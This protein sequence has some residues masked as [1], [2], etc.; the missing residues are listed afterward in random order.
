LC[1]AKE[2]GISEDHS[3]LLLLSPDARP[4]IGVAQFLDLT[5]VPAADHVLELAILPNIARCQS[6]RGC[7]REIAALVGVQAALDVPLCPITPGGEATAPV[8][9]EP[10]LCGR[11]SV[12]KVRGLTVGPSPAWQQRRLLLAGVD[13]INNLVDATNYVLLEFGQP[14]HAYDADRLSS[15]TLGVRKS[16][17][18]ET[19]HTLTQGEDDA[20]LAL[21]IGTLL[22]TSADQPVA[23][24]GI[25]GGRECSIGETTTTV[26][27]ECANFDFL[28][29]RRS[30]V[31]LSLFTEAASRFSRG[32]DIET[33]WVGLERW[34]A[35]VRETC[36]DA[37]VVGAA[38]RRIRPTEICQITLTLQEVAD[39]LGADLDAETVLN[40]LRRVGLSVALDSDR[41]TVTVP[42]Y[43]NDLTLPCDVVEEVGRL[44]GYDRLPTTLPEEALPS[45]PRNRERE[46]REAI[47]D[48]MVRQD[49][50][51]MV[52]YSFTHVGADQDLN[53]GRAESPSFDYVRLL[54]PIGPERSV[55]RRSLIAGLLQALGRNLRH[56]SAV[57][58]F[59]LG[60]VAWPEGACDEEG[61]PLE[62]E[63]LT[64]VMTGPRGAS[65]LHQRQ[66]GSVDF[67]DAKGL[68]QSLLAFLHI[69]DAKFSAADVAPYQPGVGARVTVGDSVIG[70]LG[71]V[72]PEVA[73]AFD[74]GEGRV[75]LGDFSVKAL[76]DCAG[77]D[78]KSEA[79]PRFPSV[80]LDISLCVAA[81]L[82]VA[83]V[84]DVIEQGGGALLHRAEVFDVYAGEGI[85]EGEKALAFRIWLNAG[86]RTLTMDEAMDV[87][88]AI[89]GQMV[90]E[91]QATIRE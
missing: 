13:P 25:V 65:S 62:A 22:V 24:A 63:R 72:H 29:V 79:L 46:S 47:V 11:F 23:I 7:A 73:E 51:E 31:A 33:T 16:R 89:T 59:E 75:F 44:Y 10:D 71:A 42:S 12:A 5:K 2:L 53:A 6:V 69:T 48:F 74:L 82:P 55:V 32:V 76:T 54:N 8:I 36:P 40:L 45:H 17:A 41:L 14:M 43:R 90:A 58:A 87:R 66:V 91:L 77:R 3:G 68:V 34:L 70:F 60:F 88:H 64:F 52:S 84:F 67:F 81:A 18:G 56:T 1:S 19:L 15:E 78:F 49:L 37:E 85:A 80:D 9:D 4:G 86:D 20:A 27:L 28:T 21:P 61:L 38:D 30:Q 83:R 35:L 39:T 50:Q 57:Q 26:L